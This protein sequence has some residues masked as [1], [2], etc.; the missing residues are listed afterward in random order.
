[1]IKVIFRRFPNY[2]KCLCR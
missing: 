1:M 2:V